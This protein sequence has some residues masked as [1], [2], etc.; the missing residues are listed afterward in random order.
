MDISK[1]GIELLKH[2]EGL[3][4]NAY[5]CSA[6]IPSIGYGNTFYEDGKPVKMGETITRE[7]AETLLPNI[8]KKFCQAVSKHMVVPVKPHEF[9]AL[10]S[11]AYNAGIGAFEGST[12]LKK[13]KAQKPAAEIAA[14]FHKW[15]KVKNPKTKVLEPSD[16]LIRRRKAEAHLYQFG[17]VKTFE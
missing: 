12:L 2:F 14:E 1:L 9:D 7:R 3:R 17:E 5:K 16:G 8:L 15:I 10:V 6:G 4:L 11:F 13:V